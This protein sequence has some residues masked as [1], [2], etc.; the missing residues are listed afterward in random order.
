MKYITVNAHVSTPCNVM[1]GV[2]PPAGPALA[3]RLTGQGQ[4][5][6]EDRL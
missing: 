3:V 4:P 5:G 1:A 2:Q 6:W